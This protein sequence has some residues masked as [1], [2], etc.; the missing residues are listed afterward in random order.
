VRLPFSPKL[1]LALLWPALAS[2]LTATLLLGSFLPRLFQESAAQELLA[3]V[4]LVS[5]RIAE[6]AG[7]RPVGLHD[8][9]SRLG[10]RSGMRITVVGGDG[11]VL[12]DSERGAAQVPE[13]DNHASR[14]EVRQALAGGTGT[15]IRRSDTTAVEYAYAAQAV[16]LEGG[17][18][19]V[20]RLALPLDRLARL[21]GRLGLA[22]ALAM[23]AALAAMTAA[24][25]WLTRRLFRPLARVV[26]GAD[27]L[28]R[29]HLAHRLEVPEE[30]ELATLAL[31]LNRLASRV[32]EQIAAVGA[33][34]DHL[35]AILAS[36]SEGVLVTGPDGR[37]RFANA[38]LR[39]LLGLAGDV[40]GRSP[41]ELSR[42]PPLER[43]VAATLRSGEAGSGEMV[44]HAPERRTLALTTAALADRRGAVVVARDITAFLR[45]AEM[46]RDFVANVSHELKSP[47]AAIRGYAE[48]LA[49]GALDDPPAARRFTARILEQCR[50]LQALL[51]DLLTLSRLEGAEGASERQRVE[52]GDL[53]RRGVE[54]LAGAA[55]E[56]R[57]ELAVEGDAVTVH[58]DA[59]ALERM[60]LN[61][62]DNA[63]KYNRPGGAVRVRVAGGDREALL[64]VRDTGIGI[65]A[66]ALPRIFERFYRVDK[67]RSRDEGGT[68]LGLAIV[69]HVAQQ[70]GGRVE[71]ESAL[72]EGSAFRVR[73]PLAAD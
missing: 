45:L 60:V 48:T 52:L 20:V 40:A 39:R 42:Q 55:A 30:E 19:V 31:S 29:G 63:L 1:R 16:T 27:A 46:R 67:G 53:A 62:L 7:A 61:L 69:K 2:L 71:V 68:G 18:V 26:A 57:V 28:A 73:L 70:H 64:E 15:A 4:R 51:E 36:M 59:D 44:L 9:V 49:D 12:A 23:L 8:L 47:L 33:E 58:G 54:L 43:L 38:A 22:L 10:G 65:P 41:L 13:M 11:A 25:W 17:R 50:R 21:Q 14:P 5:P 32:E 35:Q 34:R 24:S 3:S 72:G 56:R 37:A 66:D 6:E